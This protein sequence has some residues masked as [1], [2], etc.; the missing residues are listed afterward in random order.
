MAI[1]VTVG[2]LALL[3]VGFGAMTLHKSEGSSS[4]FTSDTAVNDAILYR[5]I[6]ETVEEEQ[7]SVVPPISS[8]EASRPA[9]SVNNGNNNLFGKKSRIRS[10]LAGIG[11]GSVATASTVGK[12]PFNWGLL[13][14]VL[15]GGYVAYRFL[16]K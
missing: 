16:R 9:D 1:G 7:E 8:S 14:G 6:Y 12:K 13:L 11:L 3:G 5:E 15:G 10:F 2:L 4:L